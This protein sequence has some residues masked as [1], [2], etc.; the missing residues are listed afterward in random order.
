MCVTSLLRSL[1]L[2]MTVPKTWTKIIA[3]IFLGFKFFDK[4][5]PLYRSLG[6]SYGSLG[7]LLWFLYTGV[8]WL[9][10]KSSFTRALKCEHYGARYTTSITSCERDSS[11]RFALQINFP[12]SC[13]LDDAYLNVHTSREELQNVKI[14]QFWSSRNFEML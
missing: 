5:L 2:V 8:S 10:S 7:F 11:L 13:T 6:V 9:C 4:T 3:Q 1:I 14:L 12:R